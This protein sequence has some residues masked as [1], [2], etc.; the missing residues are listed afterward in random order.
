MSDGER[1]NSAERKKE[2]GMEKFKIRLH[3]NHNPPFQTAYVKQTKIVL[4]KL[5]SNEH[6]ITV[7]TLLIRP[8]FFNM[9]DSISKHTDLKGL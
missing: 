2:R 7:V 4:F 6:C 3:R 1:K 5:L 9:T 8:V